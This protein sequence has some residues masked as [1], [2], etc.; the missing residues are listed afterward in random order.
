MFAS[1]LFA[2]V[3]ALAVAGPV[4]AADKPA[5]KPGDKKPA[6][7]ADKPKAKTLKGAVV[8]VDGTNLVIKAG[9]EGK[10]T[11]VSTNNET[12]VTIEGKDAKLADLKADQL[13]TV[14]P[15][16]GTAQTIVVAAPKPKK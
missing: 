14:T 9:K 15:A 8:K 4:L 16:E 11:T 12:K 10:E 2:S 1:K 7:G 5:E 3:L 6:A 13:V